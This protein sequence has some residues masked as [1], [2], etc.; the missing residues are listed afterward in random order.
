MN[1]AFVL[2]QCPSIPS[3][4]IRR[5]LIQQYVLIYYPR[6]VASLLIVSLRT[7]SAPG[8]DAM[9]PFKDQQQH[10]VEQQLERSLRASS[11][12]VAKYNYISCCIKM[13]GNGNGYLI[14]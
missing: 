12:I 10:Q 7:R 8:S 2:F 13:H 14:R 5:Y 3:L 11:N 6:R 9:C 4:L 1:A